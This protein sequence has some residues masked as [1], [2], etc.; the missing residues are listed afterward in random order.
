[1]AW[2]PVDD[3]LSLI[4]GNVRLV[5]HPWTLAEGGW[6][7]R[8]WS[9]LALFGLGALILN[10]TGPCDH[11]ETLAKALA[12]LNRED[13]EVSS[14]GYVE[15]VLSQLHTS[16]YESGS[17]FVAHLLHRMYALSPGP[18]IDMRPAEG[19]DMLAA[20]PEALK[21]AFTQ[22]QPVSMGEASYMELLEFSVQKGAFDLVPSSSSSARRCFPLETSN[23]FCNPGLPKYT[24]ELK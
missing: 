21:E 1:M 9:G 20:L 22:L 4:P 10:C 13:G 23:L 24:V 5:F 19:Q 15:E 2:I 14:E 17:P 12:A 18:E 6:C 7:P 11:Y 8:T 3:P 16:L